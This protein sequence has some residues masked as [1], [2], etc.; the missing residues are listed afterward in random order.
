[1]LSF[2]KNVVARLPVS[3]NGVRI[4]VVSYS[5]N[6]R[7]EFLLSDG[8]DKTV[9]SRLIDQV[10]HEAGRTN[11]ADGLEL[12]RT[13]VFTKSGDRSN[14]QNVIII[15]TDGVPNERVNDTI[16]QATLAKGADI[17]IVA[18]GI[19]G[20]VDVEM[21][22]EISSTNTVIN[23][24]DFNALDTVVQTLAESVCAASSSGNVL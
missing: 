15:I 23:V 18:L 14:N 16:P 1:M 17:E 9:V 21:L 8:T 2:L 19:T 7:V 4:G 24:D 11:I 12:A 13:E 6:G 5:N 20:S 3:V 22:K 10:N